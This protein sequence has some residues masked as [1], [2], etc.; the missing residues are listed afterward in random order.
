MRQDYEVSKNGSL[1]GLMGRATLSNKGLWLHTVY[2]RLRLWA[3][4]IHH[5]ACSTDSVEGQPSQNLL[6]LMSKDLLNAR[7]D[8]VQRD[9]GCHASAST[10]SGPAASATSQAWMAPIPRSPET[11]QRRCSETEREG[12]QK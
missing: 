8:S 4:K 2:A 11:A 5:V 3:R 12:K 6:S 10:A 7:I 1:R 9:S